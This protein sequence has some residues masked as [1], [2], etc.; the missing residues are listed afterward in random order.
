LCSGRRFGP[1][2]AG[3]GFSPDTDAGLELLATDSCS[4]CDYVGHHVVFEPQWLFLVC[5]GLSLV[6]PCTGRRSSAGVASADQPPGIVIGVW[7]GISPRSA[8]SPLSRCFTMVVDCGVSCPRVRWTPPVTRGKFGAR[9]EA[10]LGAQPSLT[11][12]RLR[13]GPDPFPWRRGASCEL[14]QHV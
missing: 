6:A 13:H 14:R 1:R 8:C 2:R 11:A 9:L 12:V 7:M 5:L 3:A 4:Y 10:G